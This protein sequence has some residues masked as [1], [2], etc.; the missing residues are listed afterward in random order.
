MDDFDGRRTMLALRI[1][2]LPDLLTN[3]SGTDGF[4][5]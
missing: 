3:V 2:Q 1:E 5:I 4:M